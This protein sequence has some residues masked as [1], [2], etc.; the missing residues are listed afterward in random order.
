MRVTGFWQSWLLPLILVL[1]LVGVSRGLGAENCAPEPAVGST[2]GAPAPP[3]PEAP[4]A[5]AHPTPT[6]GQADFTLHTFKIVGAKTEL[7]KN[8]KKELSI[9]L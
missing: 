4:P 5:A 1:T 9:K 7:V 8:L 6:A 2:P 3:P